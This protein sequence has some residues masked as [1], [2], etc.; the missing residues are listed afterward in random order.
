M[1]IST[2]PMPIVTSTRIQAMDQIKGTCLIVMELRFNMFK[3]CILK[4]SCHFMDLQEP[5]LGVRESQDII[6]KCWIF[7]PSTP[8]FFICNIFNFV[9][10]YVC[11]CI[12]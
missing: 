2:N 9:E 3:L 5:N 11:V 10:M 8:L 4:S 6:F 12:Q 1:A 7:P